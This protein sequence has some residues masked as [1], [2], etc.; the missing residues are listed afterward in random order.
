MKKFGIYLC[1]PP[2]VDLRMEGLGRHLGE[3]LKGAKERG[4]VDFVI[5]CPSWLTANLKQL[6][7]SNTLAPDAI[8]VIAPQS[9]PLLL[10]VYRK[11]LAYTARKQ[12]AKR[13]V[14]LRKK[15]QQLF[16]RGQT[17][18]ERRLVSARNV[19]SV[20]YW[21]FVMTAFL[22]A[23]AVLRLIWA[24]PSVLLRA[25]KRL[26]GKTAGRLLPGRKKASATANGNKGQES[27]TWRLYR[28]M[29]ENEAAL[30]GKL[31]DARDD[32]VA[33]YSPTAFWPYFNEIAAPRLMC[34]PDVVL[35]DFPAGFAAVGGIGMERNFNQIETAIQ[36][37]E[38]FVT[39]SEQTKWETLVRRYGTDPEAI[40][41]VRHGANRLD[42]LIR[43][44][45]FSDNDAATEKLCRNL[46]VS[47]LQK[48]LHRGYSGFPI[49]TD[50]RFIFYASQLRPNKNI[51]SLLRAYDHLLK[52]RFIGHKL[53][54]T[55]NPREL[56]EIVEFIADNN[57]QNDVL[58][59]HGLSEQELAA[60]YHLADLA[61]NPSLSEGGCP[62][63][64]TEALSVGTPVVMARIPVT[65]EVIIDRALR[66]LM[67]F[68]PYNWKDMAN[69]IEWALQ[70][71]EL[72]LS[73]QLPVY[74]KLAQRTWRNV[75][76][77]YVAILDQI[78]MNKK[79]AK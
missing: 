49:N 44:T 55:G 72:L 60:C 42:D 3:F 79:V 25:T 39:Y 14:G 64:F 32:V 5:A 18:I 19:V 1:Y 38:Y 76:D 6:F 15:L 27:V 40:F 8:E 75:V 51:I 53:F 31:I 29:E 69:K 4:D 11:Y 10:T 61:V 62:F 36:Q 12:S 22:F 17:R 52:R 21:G 9:P 68:D 16:Q 13:R 33:W 67:C 66:E 57:L 7:E 26:H 56:D 77:E 37:G 47:A 45:G 34:V 50:L 2:T 43:V 73:R 63:T 71:H 78:S 46:L 35:T 58:C 28:M 20:A 23:A 65:E 48:D 74:E 30:I 70:N 59:L 41:V 54:L 24:L